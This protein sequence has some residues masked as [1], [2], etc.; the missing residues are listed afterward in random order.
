MA[1]TGKVEVRVI[2]EGGGD[3]SVQDGPFR[4]G[5]GTF[6][7]KIAP[8]EVDGRPVALEI[9]RGKGGRSAVDKYL[10]QRSLYPDALLILLI[11]SEEPV[12]PNA[13]VWEFIKARHGFDHPAWAEEAHAYLM[14]QCVETWLVADPA[15][16]AVHYGPKF[17]ADKLPKRTNLEEELKRD[18]QSKLEEAVG[19]LGGGYRHGDSAKLIARVDPARVARLSHGARL[20]EG[21]R[22]AIES[23]GRK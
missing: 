15:A 18:V 22:E 6:L 17:D 21:F 11:D 19:K 7:R 8:P 16:L 4:I 2:V 12:S 1:R 13:T 3:A 9:V 14:V 5:Y 10:S 23:F 20:R